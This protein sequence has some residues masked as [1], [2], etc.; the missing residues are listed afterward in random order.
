MREHDV[1]ARIGGDEFLAYCPG[2]DATTG[3]KLRRRV[4]D[5]LRAPI[6]WAGVDLYVGVSIGTAYDDGR[7]APDELMAA[8][9]RAMYE[10]KRARKRARAAAEG[11]SVPV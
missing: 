11:Q 2:T 5:A 1:V 10:R 7:G 6:R 8:A 9:D 4:E 3:E